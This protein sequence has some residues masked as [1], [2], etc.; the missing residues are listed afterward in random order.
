M[1][2]GVSFVG[3][4]SEQGTGILHPQRREGTQSRSL[5]VLD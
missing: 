5:H 1:E 3:M 2:M 4:D